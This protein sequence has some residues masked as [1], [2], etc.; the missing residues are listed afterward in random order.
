MIPS[1]KKDEV[2]KAVRGEL[3]AFSLIEMAIVLIIVGLISG[4]ALPI[5]QVMLEWQKATATAQHQEKILYALA[6]YAAQYKILPY[7]ADPAAPSG[8]QE[9]TRRRGIVP[10]ADLGL[11]ESIA[12]DGYQRW[13]TYVVDDYYTIIPKSG[14]PGAVPQQPVNKFCEKHKHPKPLHIKGFQESIALA[15]M[16]HGPQGRGAYPNPL[17]AP[18]QGEDEIQNTA[19]D[20]ELID[21]SLS[22]DP[23]NPFSHKV[24]WVTPKN[25]LA[26][27]GHAPCPPVADLKQPAG[28]VRYQAPQV[29]AKRP[30][31]GE[32]K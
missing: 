2:E 13:F 26:V 9:K 31:A 5:L 11:P 16:S 19:S 14:N 12:K 6:S 7:A 24:A 8:K 30:Q 3:P 20:T 28:E 15:I 21:R 25:L 17:A 4:T 23:L 27:Y 1:E 18:P 22:R 10:Y 32:G 29:P